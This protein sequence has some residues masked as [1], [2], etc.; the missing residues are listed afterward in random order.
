MQTKFH[1]IST[2]LIYAGLCA[3]TKDIS[4]T[5]L[6]N[7]KW[8]NGTLRFESRWQYLYIFIQTWLR[9][10]YVKSWDLLGSELLSISFWMKG[11]LRKI[12]LQLS[13]KF[14]NFMEWKWKL[15]DQMTNLKGRLKEL[16]LEC[17]WTISC[18]S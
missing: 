11:Y 12:L 1:F 14:S 8:N 3:K 16:S 10:Q 6:Q 13:Q 7:G 2:Y 4:Y 5:I 17:L 15:L 18:K 9:R